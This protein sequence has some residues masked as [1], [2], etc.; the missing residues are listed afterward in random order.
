[1]SPL[2]GTADPRGNREG[3][4][5]FAPHH[6]PAPTRTAGQQATSLVTVSAGREGAEMHRGSSVGAA[7]SHGCL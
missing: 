6:T 3:V 1:M 2:G 4:A 7:P 5:G